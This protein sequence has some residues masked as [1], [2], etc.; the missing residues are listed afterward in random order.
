MP[1]AMSAAKDSQPNI[2]PVC[3]VHATFM[4]P[5]S[6]FVLLKCAD[7]VTSFFKCPNLNCPLIYIFGRR[8]GYYTVQRDGTLIRY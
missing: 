4:V 2:I 7:D 6:E 5:H 1:T 8:E 3:P